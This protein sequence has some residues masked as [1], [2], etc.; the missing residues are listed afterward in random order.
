[1]HCYHCARGDSEDM[2]MK[3]IYMESLLLQC[4]SIGTVTFTGGEPS[5]NPEVIEWFVSI[6]E[7]NKIQVNSFYIAT[8]G[9]DISDEFILAV[10][11][12][13]LLCDER[14]MC[15]I[16]FSND[17]YHEHEGEYPEDGPLR[18]FKFFHYKNSYGSVRDYNSDENW[19]NQ[20]RY[21]EYMGDG[22]EVDAESYYVDEEGINEGALYLNCEGY[23][24]AGCNWSYELQRDPF[25][26]ICLSVE[27]V[28]EHIHNYEY[29]R[30]HSGRPSKELVREVEKRHG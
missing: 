21:E 23:V 13:Y 6:V 25:Y 19:L 22:R 20:G 14:E 8:N 18:V 16:D 10:M 9:A 3:R 15:R 4:G 7:S 17:R 27:P 29:R 26:Q 24:I 12:L 30:E 5:L 2:V 28:M 11:H 1:M